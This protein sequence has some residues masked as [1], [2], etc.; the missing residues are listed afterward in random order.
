MTSQSPT[1]KPDAT[2]HPG[3]VLSPWDTGPA[4]ASLQELLCAHGFRLKVDGDFGSITEVAVRKFQ[5][6]HS[7]RVDGIVGPQTWRA[8]L[9]T[10]QPGSRTLKRRCVGSDVWEL[11]GLLQVNG[12]NINRDGFFNAKTE[13]AIIDFQRRHHLHPDGVVDRVTL[14]F[15]WGN[16]PLPDSPKQNRW[17][18]NI[19]KWW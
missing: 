10:L 15:L 8:L 11:Q 16:L 6:R 3:L 4:I 9:T 18:P 2:I 14:K 12:Y 7:L 1:W 5:K 19:R 13:R 17:L